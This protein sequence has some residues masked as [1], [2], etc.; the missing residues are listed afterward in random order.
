MSPR[1]PSSES[2]LHRLSAGEFQSSPAPLSSEPNS[3]APC[4][5]HV[6]NLRTGPGIHKTT[7][8]PTTSVQGY[9]ERLRVARERLGWSQDRLARTWGS[10]K[11]T[12]AAYEHGDSLPPVDLLEWIEALAA[13]RRTGT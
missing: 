7:F 12:V 13:S 2:G 11:R 4:D 8:R 9:G 5:A 1:R 10:H 6:S 3:V